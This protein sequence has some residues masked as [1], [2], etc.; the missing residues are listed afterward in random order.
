MNETSSILAKFSAH[1]HDK[2]LS[3]EIK[4][5]FSKNFL[6]RENAIEFIQKSLQSSIMLS[7]KN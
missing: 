2:R 4:E 6:K 3:S 5:F 7:L 1:T